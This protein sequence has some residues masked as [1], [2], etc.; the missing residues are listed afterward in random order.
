MK[1][2]LRSVKEVGNGWQFTFVWPSESDGWI[3]RNGF[4][5]LDGRRLRK[6]LM[7]YNYHSIED[8][9]EDM[10][11]RLRYFQTKGSG[12]LID[13]VPGGPGPDDHSIEVPNYP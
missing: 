3:P 8:L 5:V 10:P 11:E 2:D 4:D 7:G 12:V 9:Q 1:A 6:F 13:I